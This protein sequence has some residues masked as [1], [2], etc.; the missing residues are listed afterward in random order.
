MREDFFEIAEHAMNK[1]MY[2]S[3]A[4]NGTLITPRV[5][6]QLHDIGIEYVEISLDG[7]DAQEHD[8]L[9][10]VRGAFE[11]S[12]AGIKNCVA[13]GIYT[14]VATTVTQDNY[15]DLPE[16]YSLSRKVGA[17]RFINFNFIPTGR[18]LELMDKDLTPR[19]ER[20]SSQVL[21]EDE[22]RA[23]LSRSP[24]YSAAVCSRCR[25]ERRRGHSSRPFPA[26]RR[27]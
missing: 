23:Q 5:A 20:R 14:C 2:V 10:G 7:K 19:A 22:R 27:T 17:G 25:R 16:I 21:V 15:K 9:G 11:R 24:F 18:G 3:L 26:G 4:S 12:I 13:A 8:S 1:S 6:A